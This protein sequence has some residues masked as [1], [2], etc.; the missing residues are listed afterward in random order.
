MATDVASRCSLCYGCEE[1]QT[2]CSITQSCCS[3]RKT[4]AR[5][6]RNRP[7]LA[8]LG[9]SS[10][11]NDRS[12]AEPATEPAAAEVRCSARGPGG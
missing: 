3:R 1:S 4:L 9:C 5:P 2:T 7:R 8:P 10:H 12:L 11:G 6:S